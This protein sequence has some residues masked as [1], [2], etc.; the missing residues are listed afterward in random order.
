M[1]GA[2][3]STSSL[4]A[5]RAAA[6]KSSALLDTRVDAYLRE[7]KLA[8]QSASAAEAIQVRTLAQISRLLRPCSLTSSHLL[9]PSVAMMRPWRSRRCGAVGRRASPCT[10][11]WTSAAMS[12]G[13]CCARGTT[14]PPPTSMRASGASRRPTSHGSSS[15]CADHA[16]HLPPPTPFHALLLVRPL[17]TDCHACASESSSSSAKPPTPYTSWPTCCSAPSARRP[18]SPTGASSSISASGGRARPTARAWGRPWTGA[19]CS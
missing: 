3:H 14:S 4:H 9:S 17:R 16:T 2:S 10:T 19:G 1:M 11:R 13:W 5:A 18:R 12:I 8:Q 6:A 15:R 7:Y